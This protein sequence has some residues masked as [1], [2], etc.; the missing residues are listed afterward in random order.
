MNYNNLCD[1][2]LRHLSE[3][4]FIKTKSPIS[5]FTVEEN[6]QLVTV[7]QKLA[8]DG[9]A[10]QQPTKYTS[11]KITIEGIE[12]LK[13]NANPYSI[14]QRSSR[15]NTLKK[16]TGIGVNTLAAIIA[17]IIMILT[18]Y[19]EFPDRI[20]SFLKYLLPS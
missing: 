7:Y 14:K 17:F 8:K 4:G 20:N 16:S 10:I 15:W 2:A 11:F 9:Y 18:F 13:K 12:A 1:R 19:F 3:H 6:D 5:D